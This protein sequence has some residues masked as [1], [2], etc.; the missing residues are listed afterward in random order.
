VPTLFDSNVFI[1]LDRQ[2]NLEDAVKS[3]GEILRE[4]KRWGYDPVTLSCVLD[5]IHRG[6]MKDQVRSMC[7]IASVPDDYGQEVLGKVKLPLTKEGKLT[8]YKLIAAGISLSKD[9]PILVSDDY[10][11]RSEFS[12]HVE[13]GE[14]MTPYQ[15]TTILD[16]KAPS[17]LMKD[18][19]ERLRRHF[20]DHQ[21]PE[22]FAPARQFRKIIDDKTETEQRGLSDAVRRYLKGEGITGS[23]RKSLSEALQV[24]ME[25]KDLDRSDDPIGEVERIMGKICAL[26]QSIISLDTL[27]PALSTLGEKL[28]IIGEEMEAEGDFK[29]SLRL[30]DTASNMLAL[31]A[32]SLDDL[33][34]KLNSRRA[35]TYLILGNPIQAA[36]ILEALTPYIEENVEI[37]ADMVWCTL[38]VTSILTGQ[39]TEANK[40]LDRM[41]V[42]YARPLREFG[43]LLFHHRLYEEAIKIYSFLVLDG[44]IN[45]EMLDP[46][47]R[48]AGILGARLDDSIIERVPQDLRREDH[49]RQDMPY[50][51][52]DHG[53]EQSMLEDPSTPNYFRDPMKICRLHTRP[54]KTMAVVWNNGISS[55]IGINLDPGID[56]KNA[57]A[58]RLNRGPVKIKNSIYTLHYNIRG[59]IDTNQDTEIE[60][61]RKTGSIIPA[62]G[63][64]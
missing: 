54:K 58:I 62:S 22:A 20:L 37:Q 47:Q 27:S 18:I 36:K 49:T 9:K 48:A 15:F 60:I 13:K 34:L 44:K 46:L 43:D 25:I 21:K 16:G 1:A 10:L 14:I 4:S 33:Y 8:D 11:L 5:E 12:R 42:G 31:T 3:A 35:V 28:A 52:K 17:P 55:R 6:V 57:D 59:E 38:A 64:Q 53:E 23:E 19:T 32:N 39:M 40:H 45:D 30:R 63:N 50:L 41:S 29:L 51:T 7:R 24:L 26:N 2:F 56:L 61:F